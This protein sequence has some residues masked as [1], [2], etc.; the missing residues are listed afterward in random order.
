MFEGLSNQEIFIVVCALFFGYGLVRL[1]LTSKEEAETSEFNGK[2]PYDLPKEGNNEAWYKTL[3]VNPGAS[4]DEIKAA[5]KRKVSQYH[6]DKVSSL[7]PEFTLIAEKMTKQ[8]NS[9]YEEAVRK[10]E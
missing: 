3:D 7:G 5:Y 10:F 4:F 8:I 2:H 9:A 6:P 1:L